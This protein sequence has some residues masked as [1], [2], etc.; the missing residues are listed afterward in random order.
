MK[1]LVTGG[2]GFIGSHVV[3]CLLENGYTPVVLDNLSSG[4]RSNLADDVSFYNMSILS[5]EIEQVFKIEKP[6][7]VI[8]LAA[9]VNVSTSLKAPVED[10]ATNILGT[11]NLLDMCKKHAVKKFIF[12][13]SSAVYGDA[14]TVIDE[15][16]PTSPLSFYG[17]S[18]LV[19]ESYIQLFQRLHGLSFTIFR[20]ANVF[21]PRQKSDGEGGVISIFINQLLNGKTPSIFGTGNQTRDFVFVEDVAKANVLAIKSGENEIINISSN[22]QISINELF[23]LLAAEISSS[24]TPNYL[25]GQSGEILHSQLNNQKA[26]QTLGWKPSSDIHTHLLKTIEHFQSYKS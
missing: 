17:T 20:Y 6:E 5:K 18:K 11:I 10:A 8:H 7:V 13:S 16:T 15:E 1:V 4:I 23:K 2:T 24:A 14:D 12:S 21:G 9:Q 19:S 25:P 22:H 3:E 26:L